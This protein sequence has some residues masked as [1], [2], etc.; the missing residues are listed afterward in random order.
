MQSFT[1]ERRNN[2]SVHV[3]PTQQYANHYVQ[4]NLINTRKIIP[5][6]IFVMIV[7]LLMNSC[8]RFPSNRLLQQHVW[9][10]YGAELTCHF[11]YKGDTQIAAIT[12]RIPRVTDDKL[13]TGTQIET[14]HS[15][16]QL[17][18]DMLY[19]PAIDDQGMF[20]EMQVQEEM[21]WTE[22]HIAHDGTDW[23]KVVQSRC[24]EWMGYEGQNR[25]SALDELRHSVVSH[26]LHQYYQTLL[27]NP[28]H[29]HVLGD[30]HPGRIMDLIWEQFG[31]GFTPDSREEEVEERQGNPGEPREAEAMMM[32][33]LDIHQC[34]I[35]VTYRTGIRYG[36]A[37]YPA[38]FVF[39]TLFG[40][41]PA[42]RLQV[43]LRE[44]SPLVYQV[45]ST[46]DDFRETLHI[47]T[48]T[49]SANVT[50]VLEGI[51][52]EWKR[53]CDGDVSEMELYIAVQNV[54]H[55]VQV[56]F[57]LPHQVITNHMDQM[58]SDSQMST[59]QFL[60]EIAEV[61]PERVAS[62]ATKL[63]KEVTWILYPESE[64]SA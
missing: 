11:D 53:I 10:L 29:I 7:R 62:V 33:L 9:S 20:E 27:R 44:R 48:G 22:H 60:K 38:L 23:D 57:D 17:L 32:E 46:L 34:K 21:A 3:L 6:A 39:H 13:I 1:T 42:S 5:S 41:T 52:T 49:S 43:G 40:A 12:M 19:D 31:C 37:L 15:A 56:G 59:A 24:L 14:I 16:V 30:I 63:R 26:K 2:L 54:M 61:T 36:S 28:I 51:D 47:T 64:Y 4:I 58:L 8:R 35:N 45:I 18:A 50:D 55:Y 25:Q